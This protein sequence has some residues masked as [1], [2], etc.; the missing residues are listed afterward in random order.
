MILDAAPVVD[1]ANNDEKNNHNHLD[2]CEP[3]L[4]LP[5]C[6]LYCQR[7]IAWVKSSLDDAP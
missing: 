7:I 3:V 2:E 5:W 1:E 6:T 4:A